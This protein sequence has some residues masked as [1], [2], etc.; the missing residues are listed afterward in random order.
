M[1]P[2]HGKLHRV[3]CVILQ[4]L[5]GVA[6][7]VSGGMDEA[8]EC[9]SVAIWVPFGLLFLFVAGGGF[10]FLSLDEKHDGKCVW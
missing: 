4:N 3:V 5:V 7:P 8:A 2:K 10:P 1:A 6:A 9:S